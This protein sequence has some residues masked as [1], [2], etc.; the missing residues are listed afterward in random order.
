VL[1]V[2]KDLD[3][4]QRAAVLTAI[5]HPVTILTGGPGTGK[6]TTMKALI[7]LLEAE[8]KRVALAAPT[9]RAAKRLSQTSDRSASTIHRLI[10]YV[11]GEG[12]KHDEETP[13]PV[14]LIVVDEA[15]MLD[16]QLTHTLLKAIKPG[17]HLL[18]VGDIDQLPSVGAGDVLRNLIASQRF[19]VTRLERI[20]R[21]GEGSGIVSNAHEI[22]QG[23]QPA[24]SKGADGDFFLDA[25][26]GAEDA[27]AKVVSL[28][29]QRIPKQ[30]KMDPLQDIQVLTPIYRGPAGVAALNSALQA[31]LNPG[32]AL[33]PER[34]FAGQLLRVGDRL[35]QIKNNYDK[36]VFNGDIG[37]L[38][39][40]SNEDQTLSVDFEGRRV[41]YDWNE[42]EELTL[43]YAI[44]VHKSQ[45]SEFRAVVMPVL[46]QHYM[47]LQ[48]NLIYTGVTRA[49]ELC[50]LVG[51][52]KALG[53]AVGNNKVAE[54]W[55]GLTERLRP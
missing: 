38:R 19:P 41:S 42:A 54:R 5:R 1:D 23:R 46:T 25:C 12:P 51:S 8:N 45:G 35:M 52:R 40:L 4:Q 28:V 6:T 11:P 17:T 34:R 16:V 39:E 13:L 48:R 31:A 49:R 47:M 9:G 24:A 10:G 33:K 53:M 43:A 55:S 27:A 32:S 44:T 37:S 14:D 15:S 18:L 20:Y 29:T 7:L 22:N 21:Q 26:E 30:F 36:N 2:V 3:Q 50:V